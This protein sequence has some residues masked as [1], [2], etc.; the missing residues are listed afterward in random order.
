MKNK[1][2]KVNSYLRYSSL[3]FQMLG[4]IA[5]GTFLGIYIDEKYNG[6]G[7][8][9]ALITVFFVIVAIYL[10]IKDLLIKKP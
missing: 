3:T 4:T 7:L 2:N 8:W 1:K 10:G 6:N 5:L 9:L